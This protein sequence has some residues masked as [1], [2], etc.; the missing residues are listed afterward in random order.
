MHTIFKIVI[1]LVFANTDSLLNTI[2]PKISA[3]INKVY[4]IDKLK[5]NL[6]T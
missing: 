2:E 5:P 4:T 1:L 3:N 6:S